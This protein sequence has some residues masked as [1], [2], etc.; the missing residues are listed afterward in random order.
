MR[1]LI[2]TEGRVHQKFK[3][4]QC[5][6]FVK[7]NILYLVVM[8]FPRPLL[9]ILWGIL[10]SGSINILFPIPPPDSTRLPPLIRS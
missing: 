4:D 2:K 7:K 6:L 8:R 10:T 9:T 5:R 1:K 3:G